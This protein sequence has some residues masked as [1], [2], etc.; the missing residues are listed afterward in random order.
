MF[1]DFEAKLSPD[2]NWELKYI[3]VFNGIFIA[4]TE[5][6]YK[7]GNK[8]ALD[9]ENDYSIEEKTVEDYKYNI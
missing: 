6:E 2:A 3:H 9:G 8:I 4:A 1:N 5:N 7:K